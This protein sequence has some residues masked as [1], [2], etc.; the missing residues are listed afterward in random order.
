MSFKDKYTTDKLIVDEKI[1]MDLMLELPKDIVLEE[2]KIV[3]S[4]DAF[5]IGEMMQEL[6]DRLELLNNRMVR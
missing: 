5:A 4:N 2:E 3:L 6:S 1:S